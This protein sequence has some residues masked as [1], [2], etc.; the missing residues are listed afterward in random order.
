ML[1]NIKGLYKKW[2]GLI[3]FSHIWNKYFD[4]TPSVDLWVDKELVALRQQAQ[5]WGLRVV[6]YHNFWEIEEWKKKNHCLWK[7]N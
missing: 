1:V 6:S 4:Y 3:I 5:E 2:R 7:K